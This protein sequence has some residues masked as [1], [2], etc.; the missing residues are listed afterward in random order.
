MTE[1]ELISLFN[2]FFNTAYARLNDF[3]AGTFALLISAF[4]IGPKLSNKMAVL[5][6]F[7]YSLYSL[8]TI[9]PTLAATYRFVSVG[10]LLKA[11]AVNPDSVSNHLFP[12]LPSK[13]LV[14]PTM[15]IFLIVAFAGSLMFFFAV[16][17]SDS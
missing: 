14:M 9:V 11:A 5:V 7:L 13:A 10:E 2:E 15:T 1:F 6:V 17:K 4:F 3:M 12:I 16:R 8:A